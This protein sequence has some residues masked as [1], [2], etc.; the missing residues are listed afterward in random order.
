MLLDTCA[1]LLLAEGLKVVGMSI[2]RL[3]A[4]SQHW[5]QSN[6]TRPSPF[7]ISA[8]HPELK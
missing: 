3:A 8:P 7:L 2:I 5:L 1:E 4:P 6:Q